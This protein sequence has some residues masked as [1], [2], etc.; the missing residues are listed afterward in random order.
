MK[1]VS[2]FLRPGEG[3]NYREEHEQELALDLEGERA[4]N[5]TWG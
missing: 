2:D 1:K 5:V 3:E 4:L